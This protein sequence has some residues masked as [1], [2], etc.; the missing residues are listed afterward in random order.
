[1]LRPRVRTYVRT[2]THTHTHTHTK[3]GPLSVGTK[4]VWHEGAVQTVESGFSAGC[5]R[6]L[7]GVLRYWISSWSPLL[8]F[9]GKHRGGPDG[10][11]WSVA[12]F[13]K[14][15]LWRTSV[16]E[17]VMFLKETIHE[18]TNKTYNLVTCGEFLDS[19]HNFLGEGPW[20][21]HLG[22]QA[23]ATR[24]LRRQLPPTQQHFICLKGS[25]VM[26]CETPGETGRRSPVLK[27]HTQNPHWGWTLANPRTCCTSSRATGMPCVQGRW[28]SNK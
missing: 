21:E 4:P 23:L 11:T 17:K 24:L 19:N 6:T 14:V 25:R 9:L 12:L 20:P 18:R 3:Q 26:W 1:V 13:V 22:D 27:T 10:D 16:Q 28:E 5:C 2:Y 8:Y 15:A 7:Q